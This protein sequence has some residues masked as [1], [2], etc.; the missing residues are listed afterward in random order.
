MKKIRK[1]VKTLYFNS[2]GSAWIKT[3]NAKQR[4]IVSEKKRFECQLMLELN[5]KEGEIDAIE[6][7]RKIGTIQRLDL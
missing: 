2:S 3:N 1:S 6:Y 5:V 4:F 7:C